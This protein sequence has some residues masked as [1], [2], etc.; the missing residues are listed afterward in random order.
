MGAL[1]YYNGEYGDIEEMTVP[2]LNRALYF[3]DGC[4]DASFIVDGHVLDIPDH[5]DR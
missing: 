2:I 5:I 1:G 4:Y 3:G